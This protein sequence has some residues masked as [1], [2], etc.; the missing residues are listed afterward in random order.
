MDT[1][2]ETKVEINIAKNSRTHLKRDP[3]HLWCC[4]AKELIQASGSQDKEAVSSGHV[5]QADIKGK[6]N[7]VSM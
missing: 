4:D 5:P 6:Y 7:Q 3:K 2:N 1:D